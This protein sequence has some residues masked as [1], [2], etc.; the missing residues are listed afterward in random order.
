VGD[1]AFQQRAFERIAA[2]A[3][4]GIPVVVVSHQLDRIA[5][6]C[7]E[8]ILL[9]RGRVVMQGK[10]MECIAA[11]VLGQSHARDATEDGSPVRIESIVSGCGDRIRSGSTV[12]LL[13]SG[14]I[15]SELRQRLEHVALRVRALGT[16]A[17]VFSCDSTSLHVDMPPLG[18]FTVSVE[19]QLNV[20]PGN[21]VIE[22]SVWDPYRHRDAFT[23]PPL[24]LTVEEGPAFEGSVQMNPR[25]RLVA[26]PASDGRA[27]S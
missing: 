8:A 17:F 25:M 18:P 5:E 1:Y 2:L 26:P 14:R 11:Y 12:T 24:L 19:L 23:G 21:Y 13:V 20:P 22:P 7:T 16:G 4:S 6:L 9:D 3:R 10:P 15:V 27:A